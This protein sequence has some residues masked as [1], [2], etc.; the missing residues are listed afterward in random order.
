M[1]CKLCRPRI[2]RG[3]RRPDNPSLPIPSRFMA[4]LM[5][6]SLV[7]NS[8]RASA[9]DKT[10][11]FRSETVTVIVDATVQDRSGNPLPCLGRSDFTLMEDGVE[12]ELAGFDRIGA[13][14]CSPLGSSREG[15]VA[16]ATSTPPE[17]TAIIFHELGP[18]SRFASWRSAQ[19]F[20][21]ELKRPG[22]F[23][24]VYSLDTILRSVTPYTL[25]PKALLD[26]VREAATRPG[27]PEVAQGNVEN[28]AGSG[29]CSAGSIGEVK[30]KAVL[31]GLQAVVRSL[32]PLPGRKNILLF[33][34]G[35][36]VANDGSAID[37][38][39]RL[40][41]QANIY[42][43]SIQT[44]DAGG[45]RTADW[46][47][48]AGRRVA[49]YIGS[50]NQGGLATTNEDPNAL[51]ALDPAMALARLAKETSGTFVTDTNDLDGA[52]RTLSRGMHTY[53]QIGYQPRDRR[54]SRG[55]HAITLRVSVPNAR[56]FTRSGY[57]ED[58][59]PDHNVK[60][61]AT[62][63]VAPTLILDSGGN[64][65]DFDFVTT[66]HY[67]GEKL[68]FKVE[69]PVGGL[70]FQTSSERFDAGLT[71]VVRTVDAHRNVLGAASETRSIGG[72]ADQL[73]NARAR[74]IVF[75]K[76]L[77]LSDARSVEVIAYDV[78]SNRSAVQRYELKHR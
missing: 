64:P 19:M 41:A 13:P 59:S 52:I 73:V 20:I 66:L 76:T 28:A 36:R 77:V 44:I 26:G 34:E 24:G 6:A 35:F 27:C 21:R 50:V 30:V 11:T 61:V 38:L 22:E 67:A 31:A 5:L 49:G 7:G 63:A 65:Q 16:I 46:R 29:A 75:N 56:V 78:L 12:Q 62:A 68:D 60:R 4:V 47:Q 1:P 14:D 51:L 69:V 42:N 45:L 54:V 57:Y 39:Q 70:S 72:P 32:A 74:T 10:E 23:V 17:I 15:P 40:I 33:S 2:R 25:D 55:S 53:Y 43:V 3:Q 18:E 71:V 48:E 9:Q 58:R 8:G 37:L